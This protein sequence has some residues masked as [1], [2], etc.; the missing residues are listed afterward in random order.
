MTHKIDNR[1]LLKCEVKA[2]VSKSGALFKEFL[3]F[4]EGRLDRT[5]VSNSTSEFSHGMNTEARITKCELA[6]YDAE[7]EERHV[8]YGQIKGFRFYRS[9]ALYTVDSTVKLFLH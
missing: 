9:I 7:G 5:T 3:E 2:I 1:P 4:G 6:V 8:I